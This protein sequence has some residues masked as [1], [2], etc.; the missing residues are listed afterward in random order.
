MNDDLVEMSTPNNT[1]T[2]RVRA[3]PLPEA[4]TQ[5]LEK[6]EHLIKTLDQYTNAKLVDKSDLQQATM[7]DETREH[8]KV[9]KENLKEAF[10]SEGNGWT[11]ILDKIW[12]FGPRK[13]GS[14]VLLNRLENYD[15]PS[16]WACLE[17][18]K[19]GN[20]KDFDHSI[21][22]GF[23]MAT[24]AG[25]LCEEPIRGVCF[26]VELWK[27]PELSKSKQQ[28][29]GSIQYD[30]AVASASHSMD[31]VCDNVENSSGI[32]HNC[33]TNNIINGSDDLT[34]QFDDKCNVSCQ[35]SDM[36]IDVSGLS[37]D[38]TQ[39]SIHSLSP[40]L[41]PLSPPSTPHSPE[42]GPAFGYGQLTG[43]LMTLMMRVCR[44]SFQSQPQR[45]VV[46]MYTCVIQAPTD[47]LGTF[48]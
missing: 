4:V 12:A 11:D 6:N 48:Y 15:R 24:L 13:V 47:V 28:Q 2:L 40:P 18:E 32:G 21:V 37:L 23:Q 45:L 5:L 14:N 35:I 22:N 17:T 3:R 39:S 43:Q 33:D 34:S 10:A 41:S 8:L 46:A 30:T 19:V 1:C 42:M 7:T 44:K 26:V 29:G 20:I 36:H 9:F 27:M 38:V 31:H 25:P 16:I